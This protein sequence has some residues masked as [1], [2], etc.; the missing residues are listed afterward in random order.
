MRTTAHN[1]GFYSASGAAQQDS[2][3]TQCEDD[4]RPCEAAQQDCEGK[5]SRSAVVGTAGARL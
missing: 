4:F 2:S 5:P 1:L 3:R